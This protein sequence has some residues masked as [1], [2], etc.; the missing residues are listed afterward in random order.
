MWAIWTVLTTFFE[1]YL[2]ELSEEERNLADE[3][4]KKFTILR[5]QKISVPIMDESDHAYVDEY[6]REISS[7]L[8]D[9]TLVYGSEPSKILQNR[10]IELANNL[11]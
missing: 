5:G 3:Y 1:L 2:Q 6:G 10:L 7:S 4:F 8:F 9:D 11:E